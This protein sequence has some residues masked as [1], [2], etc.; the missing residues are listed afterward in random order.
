MGL[1]CETGK[2]QT[3]FDTRRNLVNI[4]LRKNDKIFSLAG[5]NYF[6]KNFSVLTLLASSV[7]SWDEVDYKDPTKY[8]STQ[9]SDRYRLYYRTVPVSQIFKSEL[10]GKIR[11]IPAEF[12]PRQQKI[13]RSITLI[14]L[15]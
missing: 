12:Y 13:I 7:T 1:N 5:M 2:H 11:V 4:Y 10:G 15:T 3:S 8:I 6:S 14:F 9:L